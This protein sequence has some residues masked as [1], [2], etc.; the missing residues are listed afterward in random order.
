MASNFPSDTSDIS[1]IE[2][3]LWKDYYISSDDLEE[4]NQELN[5]ELSKPEKKA[6][7]RK[8]SEEL[9]NITQTQPK[10]RK[11]RR[12]RGKRKIRPKWHN[13]LV[14]LLN[15]SDEPSTSAMTSSMNSLIIVSSEDE[16]QQTEV[17][18]R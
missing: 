15:D 8:S 4:L 10:R 2:D 9:P 1:D 12:K 11:I 17:D 5:E 6:V 3:E 13:T 7:K 16:D 14:D 18:T